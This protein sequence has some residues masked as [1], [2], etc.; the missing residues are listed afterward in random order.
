MKFTFSEFIFPGIYFSKI[1]YFTAN[2]P[3][4]ALMEEKLLL[5]YQR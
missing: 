2:K 5:G 3:G 4:R 1:I